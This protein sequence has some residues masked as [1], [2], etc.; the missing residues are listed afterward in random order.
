MLSH[1][2]QEK[3]CN[4]LIHHYIT[5]FLDTT[6]NYYNIIVNDFRFNL[7]NNFSTNIFILNLALADFLY[8]FLCLSV[9]TILFIYKKWVWG[10]NVCIIFANIVH[11]N[12]YSCW[13]SVAM[14]ALSRCISVVNSGKSTILSSRRNQI[15]IILSIR[16]YGFAILIPTNLKVM[17]MIY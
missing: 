8:C 10:F 11:A 17:T 14:I 5:Y 1:F 16:I 15:I 4:L 7:H 9:H 12:A 2:V 13:L 6:T 3:N